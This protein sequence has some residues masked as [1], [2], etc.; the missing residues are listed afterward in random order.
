MKQIICDNLTLKYESKIIVEN[1]SFSVEKGDYLCVVGEN[2]SGKTT[3][4]RTLLGL[5][6]PAAGSL[7]FS[8][9]LSRRDMGYLPQQT[10]VQKDFPAS[11]KE[12]VLSGCQS[13][14]GIRPW[15]NKE[16]KQLAYMSMQRMNIENLAGSCYR[17]LSGGQQQRVLLAR[18]FCAASKMMILDEPVTGLDPMA[19]AEMYNLVSRLNE[20]G[21]TVIMISHDVQEALQR[22]TH[23]LHLGK[24]TFFGTREEYIVQE[25]AELSVAA[26]EGVF[27]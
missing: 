23:I 21:M 8:D 10:D 11:V 7:E 12:I 6:A 25:K 24:K 1:L 5:H 27:K 22:A 16:E 18:A 2:G 4:I 26:E 13:R 17:E 14:A 15:Y 20:E 3:L 19:A 9:G